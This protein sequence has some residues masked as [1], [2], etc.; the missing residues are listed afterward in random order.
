MAVTRFCKETG[1][2]FP[3]RQARLRR[4]L[5]KERLSECDEGRHTKKVR[6]GSGTHRV[7]M[8]HRDAVEALLGETFPPVPTVPGAG[9]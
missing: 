9:R 7:L 4:D 8:L 2:L 5:E 1:E 6:I 3:I